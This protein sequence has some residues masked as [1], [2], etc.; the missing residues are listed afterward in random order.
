MSRGKTRKSLAKAIGRA[1]TEAEI[2]TARALWRRGDKRMWNL[3]LS[4]M[5]LIKKVDR[6][7]I[8]AVDVEAE[9]RTRGNV[10]NGGC[11]AQALFM[12]GAFATVGQAK[13][14][15]NAAGEQILG[16]RR[17]VRDDYERWFVYKADDYWVQDVVKAAV[18]KAGYDFHTLNVAECRLA[19]EVQKGTVLVQYAVNEFSARWMWLGGGNLSS[20]E[21]CYTRRIFKAYAVTPNALREKL[22]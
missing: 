6:V 21:R 4:L 11:T 3:G 15:L 19:E 14:A 8:E 2:A 13:D 7:P 10:A 5:K 12:V 1:P 22:E 17:E 16:R 9:S 20:P 18:V